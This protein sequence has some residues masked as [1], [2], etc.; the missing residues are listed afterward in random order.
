MNDIQGRRPGG[1]TGSRVY[2]RS[3]KGV[4]SKYHA[5]IVK[6]DPLETNVAVWGVD[7]MPRR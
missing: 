6:E 4:N 5:K 7:I 1:S 2:G 3:F